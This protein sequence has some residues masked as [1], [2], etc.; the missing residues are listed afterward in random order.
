MA[1][2]TRE[3][4]LAQLGRRGATRALSEGVW[5][6]VLRGAYT[7]QSP[8]F[9][10][11]I[12]A[13]AALLLLPADA[14]VA[15]RCLLWLHGIDVLPTQPR[16]EV[17]VPRDRVVPRRAGI[18]ARQASLPPDDRRLVRG[19]RCLRLA[20]GVADLLR[21]LPLV[22]A[23]VVADAAQHAGAVTA[24]HLRAE[25]LRHARLA[26]IRQARQAVELSSPLAESPPESRLRVA[27]VLAGLSPVPQYNVH[28]PGGRWLA[29][30][31]LAFP[32]AKVAVEYDGRAVHERP[33][34]FTRDRQ[35]QNALVRA[36]WI[37][38]R[39]TAEDL[40]LRQS[41]VVAEVA[42]AVA[43]AQLAA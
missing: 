8:P 24:D 20:R 3:V 17:V 34:V 15:D 9:D 28:D 38:L 36:G 1:V 6:R 27:L 22:E 14:Y 43:A 35:R 2:T 29:R 37:V 42:A 18:A 31:D 4:L 16:L 13:R 7:D 41:Y 25:L 10:L 40:R 21:M 11:E 23:V 32:S 30:L 5:H 19:V 12:R 39:Y 33:D 26:G